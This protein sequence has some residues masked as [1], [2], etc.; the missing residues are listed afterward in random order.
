[1]FVDCAVYEAYA[2]SF[3]FQRFE[4]NGHLAG[5]LR[6][7]YGY[8]RCIDLPGKSNMPGPLKFDHPSPVAT[9][10]IGTCLKTMPIDIRSNS[11][12]L[13]RALRPGILSRPPVL[14]MIYKD[15]KAFFYRGRC[16]DFR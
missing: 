10:I 15:G 4:S 7:G 9:E 11:H 13:E 16:N 8:P 12:F 3:I 5:F 1:M 2:H 14:Q 6:V